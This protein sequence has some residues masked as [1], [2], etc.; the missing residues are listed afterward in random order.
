[1]ASVNV[2]C[3]VSN[4]AKL[5]HGHLIKC[6]KFKNQLLE[7]ERI[8]ILARCVP[9]DKKKNKKQKIVYNK[10]NGR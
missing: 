4:K 9:E 7:N 5:C 6:T 3:F 10:C 8:E 1:M 2:G